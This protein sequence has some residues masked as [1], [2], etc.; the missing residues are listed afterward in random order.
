M[1]VRNCQPSGDPKAMRELICTVPTLAT[2]TSALAKAKAG[3]GPCSRGSAGCPRDLWRS[4]VTPQPHL[5]DPG[6]G[7]LMAQEGACLQPG[8]AATLVR[9]GP[10]WQEKEMQHQFLC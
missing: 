9:V 4:R 6:S 8:A 5:R 3:Q 2:I 10:A 7:V 1:L